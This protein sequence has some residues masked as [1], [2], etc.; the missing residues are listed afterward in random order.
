M[1]SLPEPRAHISAIPG[2]LSPGLKVP[3]RSYPARFVGTA[4]RTQ[5]LMNVQT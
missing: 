2:P 3:L 4:V 1:S 5:V